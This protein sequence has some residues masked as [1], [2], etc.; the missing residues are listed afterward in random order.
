MIVPDASGC[1]EEARGLRVAETKRLTLRRFD[2][3]DAA[4]ILEL[5]NDPAWLRFIGNRNI[6]TLE[7]ARRYIL[8]GP[9]RMYERHGFGLWLVELK[10]RCL[11]VGMCG[12]IKRDALEDVDIGF[13]LLAAHRGR[14]YAFEAASATMCYAWTTLGLARLVAIASL[15][16]DASER[17]LE[18]LG[19]TFERMTR[20]DGDASDVKLYAARRAGDP[21]ER[22]A[23]EDENC[24]D[25]IG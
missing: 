13:A 25:E 15:G 20:L 5:L 14:G 24:T 1:R 11:P 21:A 10:E 19:F 23:R 8:N 4:F 12:L 3:S 6:A 17:L 16:N 22:A 2:V 18:R 9:A 7:D